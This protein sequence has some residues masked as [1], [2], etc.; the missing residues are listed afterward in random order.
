MEYIKEMEY[1]A[2]MAQSAEELGHQDQ[3][4]EYRE[5]EEHALIMAQKEDWHETSSK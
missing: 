3:A 2:M 4:Q 5:S 1:W